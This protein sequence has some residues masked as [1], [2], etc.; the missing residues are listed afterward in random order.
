M[1]GETKKKKF[2]RLL[3]KQEDSKH[4]DF[5]RWVINRSS[6]SLNTPQKSLLAKGMNFAPAPKKSNTPAIIAEVENALNKLKIHMD[7]ADNIRSRLV[8]VL[9]KPMR[10][11][12]NLSPLQVKA[13]KELR[14]DQD[15]V[16]L[17]ADKG[18]VTVVMDTK[19]YDDKILHLLSDQDTYKNLKIDPTPTLQTKMNAILLTLKKQDK[20]PPKRC[21]N[22]ITPQ[23]YG[24]PKIHQP[25]VP[26][27]T[28]SI[29]TFV[30]SPITTG[31]KQLFS[32]Q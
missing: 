6:K 12:N 4:P 11:H 18:Y 9:N 25:D 23:L 27:Q 19:E 16:I 15:I 8:G 29:K 20:L 10:T 2:D 28:N 22:G 1:Q 24:L 7:T 26:P 13:L 32:H 21:S 5:D 30:S 17:P 14:S 3:K 31:W